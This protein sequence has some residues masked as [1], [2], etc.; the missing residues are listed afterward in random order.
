MLPRLEPGTPEIDPVHKCSMDYRYSAY[1][2]Q[3]NIENMYVPPSTL[4][5][6]PLRATDNWCQDA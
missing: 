5:T 3:R 4:Y 1:F 6:Y 2:S